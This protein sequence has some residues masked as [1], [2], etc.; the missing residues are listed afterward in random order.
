MEINSEGSLK[1]P[2]TGHKKLTLSSGL[3]LLI[4]PPVV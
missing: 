1:N 2:I 3:N 4:Y